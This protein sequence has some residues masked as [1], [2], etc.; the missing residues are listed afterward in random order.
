[1]IAKAEHLPSLFDRRWLIDALDRRATDARLGLVLFKINGLSAIEDLHGLSGRDRAIAGLGERLAERLHEIAIGHFFA[2]EFF[3]L[4]DGEADVDLKVRQIVDRAMAAM[5]LPIDI[6][7]HPVRIDLRMGVVLAPDHGA[8]AEELLSR[9]ITSLNVA[10]RHHLAVAYF[11]EDVSRTAQ[12]R[13]AINGELRNALERGEFEIFLQPKAKLPGNELVGFEALLRWHRPGH[14][15][16]APASFIPLAEESGL[17]REIDVW[18]VERACAAIKRINT[19]FGTDF[20]VSVNASANELDASTYVLTV[21]DVLRDSGIPPHWLEIEMTETTIA[22]DMLAA[23]ALLAEFRTMGVKVSIDDFGMGYSSLH[24]L[25]HFPVSG[26]K[27][28]RSFVCE[29]A[30]SKIARVI[31]R[32]TIE[33]G[34]ALGLQIIA[35]GVETAAQAADLASLG[36]DVY[37]GY[38]LSRALPESELFLWL[39]DKLYRL[40]TAT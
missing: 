2:D 31:I 35:E 19:A 14:G 32:A 7:G 22:E 27:I 25:R 13:A 12:D 37:Q 21:R 24:R 28:D 20:T 15:L 8:S 5:M 33:L 29:L 1:M 34:H 17:I 6:A 4:V 9:A 30:M 26:L 3:A 40:P 11:D 10:A 39:Q 16:V 18:V 38:Y 36:V 23:S